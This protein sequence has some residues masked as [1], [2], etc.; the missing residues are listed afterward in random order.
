MS[1]SIDVRKQKTSFLANLYKCSNM[2]GKLRTAHGQ[3]QAIAVVGP[4]ARRVF[5]T[6]T[7]RSLFVNEN[8][9]IRKV[10]LELLKERLAERKGISLKWFHVN[11]GRKINELSEIGHDF[12]GRREHFVGRGLGRSS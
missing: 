10:G 3:A 12:M 7:V 6:K 11:L 1:A 4:K 9:V 5:G 8:D 2:S